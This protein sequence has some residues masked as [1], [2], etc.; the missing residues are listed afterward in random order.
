MVDFADAAYFHVRIFLAVV[1][2]ISAL[3]TLRYGLELHSHPARRTM[4][5]IGAGLLAVDVVLSSYDAVYNGFLTP[6][7]PIALINWLW[8]FGFDLLLPIWAFLL[9]RTQRQR[10]AGEAELARLAVTD[11][12]TGVLNRRGFFDQAQ[13]VIARAR[14]GNEPVAVAML[15]IDRFKT[16]NDGFGHDAGDEVLRGFAAEAAR[17]LRAGDI[18]GRFGGE[19]FVVLLPGVAAADALP[20]I[21]RLRNDIRAGVRHPA[22]GSSAVTVSAGIASLP[23]RRP[24]DVELMESLGKADAAL[25]EAKEAGRDRVAL[26]A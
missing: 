9:L 17:G 22:G 18:L 12:L 7:T 16:I 8:L 1:T 10:D 11:L 3:C 24:A 21:E 25:Y 4:A 20:T 13:A 26:A 15:D 19:E 6:G 23:G 5:F 2:G 14:R